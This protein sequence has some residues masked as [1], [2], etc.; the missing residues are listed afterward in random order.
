MSAC[1]MH[2]D[3]RC[4]RPRPGRCRDICS[5]H[6]ARRP[7]PG[8]GGTRLARALL[9]LVERA[10]LRRLCPHCRV[11]RTVTPEE[12]ACLGL[13]DTAQIYESPG[14]DVCGDGFLGR[15]ALFGLLQM[16][17]ELADLIR[18]ADVS[19]AALEAWRGQGA[20]SLPVSVRATLLSGEISP[21]D[22]G[23]FLRP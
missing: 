21:E 2:R 16:D 17:G 22:A 10:S 14:C 12:A 4:P 15:R 1:P 11:A 19:A 13:P 7:S 3:A 9:G 8:R 23:T 5:A 20:L 6:A 18:S